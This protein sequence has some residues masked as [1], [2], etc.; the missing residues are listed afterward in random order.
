[1][2]MFGIVISVVCKFIYNFI[3]WDL[4]NWGFGIGI[5]IAIGSVIAI[6]VDFGRV[7][8]INKK[9]IDEAERE[10]VLYSSERKP[11]REKRQD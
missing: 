7:E 2:I 8:E 4:F 6:F 1:M 5:I 9:N 11:R 10:Y 3:R